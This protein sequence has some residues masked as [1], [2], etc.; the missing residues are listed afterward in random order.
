MRLLRTIEGGLSAKRV[1]V[2]GGRMCFRTA[3]RK[4]DVNERAGLLQGV[5]MI[6]HG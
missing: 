1:F 3:C 4:S 5:V 6:I 2:C